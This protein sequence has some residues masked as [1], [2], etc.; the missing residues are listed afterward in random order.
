M[1]PF[2]QLLRQPLRTAAA[3]II[4]TASA[5][6]M[7][8]SWGVYRSGLAT[9]KA[10]DDGFTTLMVYD[11]EYLDNNKTT[12]TVKS[13][14]SVT[15]E[16]SEI[17]MEVPM[18][19]AFKDDGTFDAISSTLPQSDSLRAIYTHRFTN[20]YIPDYIPAIASIDSPY[21][22]SILD[23]PYNSAVLVFKV[24]DVVLEENSSVSGTYCLTLL[25]DIIAKPAVNEQYTSHNRICL[26]VQKADYEL[27][28][29]IKSEYEVGKTYIAAL[30]NS[31]T[32]LDRSA[33][34]SIVNLYVSFRHGAATGI[35]VEDIDWSKLEF[36]SRKKPTVSIVGETIGGTLEYGGDIFGISKEYENMIGYCG[37]T[38]FQFPYT[39][40]FTNG[41]TM[42]SDFHNIAEVPGTLDEFLADPDNQL[43]VDY[44]N[45]FNTMFHASCIYGTDNLNSLLLFADKTM[46]LSDGEEF[47]AEDY[48]Q[49]NNVCI[50]SET[51]AYKNGWKLGDKI[52]L[53]YYDGVQVNYQNFTKA[54]PGEYTS[55]N[56]L[57]ISCEYEIKGI[58]RHTNS[59]SGDPSDITPN[60]VFVPNKSL[61]NLGI[62]QNSDPADESGFALPTQSD[63]DF[64]S[65]VIK[66]GRIDDMKAFIEQQGWD[67]NW[68]KFYDG[69]YSE[70]KAT[71]EGIKDSADDQ[72]LASSLTC[73]AAF[74]IYIAL[75]V[76]RQRKNVG[77]MLSLGSGKKKAAGFMIAVSTI[78]AAIATVLGAIIGCAMLKGSVAKVVSEASQQ[79]D[80]AF[81]G[82]SATG[83][84]ALENTAVLPS[85]AVIAAVALL[86]VYVAAFA[87][88]S[89]ITAGKNPRLLIRK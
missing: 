13:I 35:T 89:L 4:L 70:V 84:A 50:V 63:M 44:I 75:F 81:S 34:K 47:S 29:S 67:L 36:G 85:A 40:T 77:V 28:E 9:A 10:V 62:R 71:V 88:V 41:S 69:G 64:E 23:R 20:A 86:V 8:L 19:S 5:A 51:A 42:L 24:T 30:K 74:I 33:K 11:T 25:G 76:M 3:L 12:K 54:L 56:D 68:F 1:H 6:F 26:S 60:T 65:M 58:Y 39:Q 16:S 87:I 53:N 37:D 14:N 72:L 45:N 43:W 59:F 21:A 7:C 83:H 32:D 55:E 52:T 46:Y 27:L 73:L 66:N 49:G 57:G 38:A 2:K 78:P 80:T 61:D 15:G 31:F 82:A 22:V 48:E 17:E 79:L 18:L